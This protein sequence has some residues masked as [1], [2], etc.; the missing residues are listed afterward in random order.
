[1]ADDLSAINPWAGITGVW[2]EW[3]EGD[4]GTE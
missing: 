3:M 2:A 4:D 1:M